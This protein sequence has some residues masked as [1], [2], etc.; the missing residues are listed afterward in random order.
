MVNISASVVATAFHIFSTYVFI[1]ST[2]EYICLTAATT[3][4]RTESGRYFKSLVT[5]RRP[6]DSYYQTTTAITLLDNGSNVDDAASR[7]SQTISAQNKQNPENSIYD[8]VTYIQSNKDRNLASSVYPRNNGFSKT[9][10]T[11]SSIESNSVPTRASLIFETR[12]MIGLPDRNAFSHAHYSDTEIHHNKHLSASVVSGGRTIKTRHSLRSENFLESILH[13][14]MTTVETSFHTNSFRANTEHVRQPRSKSAILPTALHLKAKKDPG[15]TE[16]STKRAEKQV[17]PN[18]EFKNSPIH[19][20][21]AVSGEAAVLPCNI[22]SSIQGDNIHLVLWYR[23]FV[24]TPI[25][26][27][28]VR[29]GLYSRPKEWADPDLL[30]N[31]AHFS[32]ATN[33]A[34]LVINSTSKNDQAVYRCRVDFR[35]HITTHARVNLT[36]IEPI[37]SVTIEDD[38]GVE[39]VG[40]AGPYALG[41]TP[42]LSCKVVGGDPPPYITWWKN[43]HMFDQAYS[44][45]QQNTG[46]GSQTKTQVSRITLDP[47]GKADLRTKYTCRGGNHEKAPV[48]EAV[49]EIDMNFGPENVTVRGLSGPVSTSRVHQVICEAR[50][51]RPPAILTWF[52]DGN[53]VKSV[54]H[55]TSLDGQVSSST[56]ELALQPEDEGTILTCRAENPELPAAVIEH[57]QTLQILYPP[58]VR[59]RIGISLDLRSIK[60]GDD[61]YFDCVINAR[62]TANKI[63][64]A[65][66]GENLVQNRSSGVIMVGKSLVLQKVG[67]NQAGGYSCSATNSQGHNTSSAVVLNVEYSPVCRVEQSDVYGVGRLER[68]TV[69]CRVEADP[70][71]TTYRWAFNNTGEFVDIPESHYVI[72]TGGELGQ[73][74]DLRYS[75]VSDLDYGTLLCW[76]RNRVGTQ[77]VPCTFTVFPAGKPDTVASCKAVNQTEESVAVVCEPGYSGGV[78][79]SFLL[80]A[81]DDGSLTAT[82]RSDFP[83]LE[84]TGL[85]PGT[86]YNLR[87]YAE[88]S[89]G[90]S[91]PY[92][93]NAFTLT[94]VAERRTAIGTGEEGQPLS[95]V[96]GSVVGASISLALLILVGFFVARCKRHD[97]HEAHSNLRETA[98]EEP[99]YKS[100]SA[101]EGDVGQPRARAVPGVSSSPKATTSLSD[102]EIDT[103]IVPTCDLVSTSQAPACLG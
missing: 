33:P 59:V 39:L 8:S 22:T 46:G 2:V 90:R 81:W 97:G 23:D 91:Q 70:P 68:T 83:M 44:H 29:K 84:T 67:R 66:N 52:L 18:E 103:Q 79:Q 57:S 41:S 54:S 37:T 1:A 17:D 95:P 27:Y 30:D 78:N 24:P 94:D 15:I 87:V 76:A 65:V 5:L 77:R 50:G 47:L 80:Q 11:H 56:L 38:N 26:S 60:E 14:P 96:I 7:I 42:S 13:E 92:S 53:I 98:L 32:V 82:D 69:T 100:C 62:P 34:A 55:I 74:S 31:R 73:R 64:W 51:S 45:Q 71:A 25:Y 101:S 35:H 9:K 6:S 16:R 19:P 49:V 48:L 28:D 61:V 85:R 58:R 10:N 89:M 63:N 43:G 88:N 3:A 102:D 20:S 99:S 12:S 21:V 72:K 36:I 93:F 4:T 75:P 86:R 40:A